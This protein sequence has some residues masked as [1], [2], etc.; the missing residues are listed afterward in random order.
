MPAGKVAIS[1]PSRFN[2]L[3]A[4]RSEKMPA[5]KVAIS[6]L[7]RDKTLRVLR[8]SK[9]L[10]FKA[11][12]SLEKSSSVLKEDTSLKMSLGNPV[13]RLPPRLILV[14]LERSLKSLPFKRVIFFP[15]KSNDPV[16]AF[17]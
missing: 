15:D 13:S 9:T 2:S 10:A 5:G 11:V 17:S 7:A 3:R 6:L 16:I 8:S 4:V 12:M 1:L 14:M